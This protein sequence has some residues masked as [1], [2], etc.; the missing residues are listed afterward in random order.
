MKKI[1]VK[2]DSKSEEKGLI[3]VENLNK[4]IKYAKDKTWSDWDLGDT[5]EKFKN[6]S[7]IGISYMPYKDTQENS[8]SYLSYFSSEKKG[9]IIDIPS[10]EKIQKIFKDIA[11][12]NGYEE[13]K[14][15]DILKLIEKESKEKTKDR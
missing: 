7:I 11:K 12:K 5:I 8:L 9:E 4:V 6:G 10:D 2:F 13:Y 3:T 15:K 14:F 1:V